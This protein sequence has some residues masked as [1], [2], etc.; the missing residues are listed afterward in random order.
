MSESKNNKQQF[1]KNKNSFFLADSKNKGS[2]PKA[3][4]AEDG[5]NK[6]KVYRITVDDLPK[7]AYYYWHKD[8]HKVPIFMRGATGMGKAALEER[9]GRYT[10]WQ[11]KA[12]S[13]PLAA[14]VIACWNKHS[15]Q[16]LPKDL[17]KNRTEPFDLSEAREQLATIMQDF[18]QTRIEEK[19]VD[20]F[21]TKKAMSLGEC[22]LSALQK[23]LEGWLSKDCL[24]FLR[25]T[26]V[27]WYTEELECIKN[28]SYLTKKETIKEIKNI[29]CYLKKHQITD[30]VAYIDVGPLPF[31]E[32]HFEPILI[33]QD[34]IIRPLFWRG[35]GAYHYPT[36]Q[37]IYGSDIRVFN[38][39]NRSS[40]NKKLEPQA[41]SVGCET[42]SVQIIKELLKNNQVQLKEKTYRFRFYD[43]FGALQHFFLT[44]PLTLR[45]SQNKIY[46]GFL[47][48]MVMESGTIKG[49]NDVE[50]DSIEQALTKSLQYAKEQ[51]N[52]QIEKENQKSLD[53]LESIRKKWEADYA[54]AVQKHEVFEESRDENKSSHNHYLLYRSHKLKNKSTQEDSKA[55]SGPLLED[56]TGTSADS[57]EDKAELDETSGVVKSSPRI[58]AMVQEL[59]KNKEHCAKFIDAMDDVRHFIKS[60]NNSSPIIQSLL[61]LGSHVPKGLKNRCE[62]GLLVKTIL[63]SLSNFFG[64]NEEEDFRAFKNELERLF[65]SRENRSDED[66]SRFLNELLINYSDTNIRVQAYDHIIQQQIDPEVLAPYRDKVLSLY[67]VMTMCRVLYEYEALIDDGAANMSEYY[68]D[69]GINRSTL[70]AKINHM[71]EKDKQLL[72]L[73]LESLWQK[74][75]RQ[76]GENRNYSFPHLGQ[77]FGDC[78]NRIFDWEESQKLFKDVGCGDILKNL[79][80]RIHPNH[81]SH[82]LRNSPL[83]FALTGGGTFLFV[84]A[85]ENLSGIV[86]VIPSPAAYT[87][88]GLLIT[89]ALFLAIYS[90]NEAHKESAAVP[91][92]EEKTG[93]K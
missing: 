29:Q 47:N 75:Y 33:S 15:G 31:K 43:H 69:K 35:D 91:P 83:I 20:S 57:K 52:E 27:K 84:D 14:A 30:F 79:I 88:A 23:K 64:H 8:G 40:V 3:E 37:E 60:F 74:G 73:L 10:E 11:K 38:T 65:N 4:D 50:F 70:D 61:G 59:S 67:E 93:L 22:D 32:S 86:D 12:Q 28:H 46:L 6:L 13:Y 82:A 1:M 48:K 34:T 5:A 21:S 54:V 89:V 49:K 66:M 16:P 68:N 92:P 24:D 62:D 44:S 41:G 81:Q 25:R 78:E 76:N 90:Y 56:L 87:M 2:E 42:L 71:R 19:Q 72:I 45:Y 9:R 7:L 85:A 58:E 77:G 63:Q 17:F 36:V 55:L 26:H 53:Q 18:V 39:K 51:G 80:A